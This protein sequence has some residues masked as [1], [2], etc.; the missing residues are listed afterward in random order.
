MSLTADAQTGLGSLNLQDGNNYINSAA[1]KYIVKPKNLKGINGFVFDYEGETNLTLQADITDHF[2]ETN[3][4]V[5]DHIAIRPI[6]ITLKGYVGELVQKA[7]QGLVGALASIQNRLTTVPA[8]LGRYTPSALSTIQK[9]ITQAQ[10]TVNTIN[11]GLARVQN[12]IG[13]FPGATPQK[14]KQQKAFAQL[15]SLYLTRQVFT[16]DTPYGPFDSMVIET[17]TFV[18]PE[19]T[20]YWSDITVTLKQLRFVDTQSVQATSGAFGGRGAQQRQDLT[21]QGKTKG[22]PVKTSLLYSFFSS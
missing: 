15:Q 22:T 21:S 20:K 4:P 1:N 11:Q 13:L 3:D 19:D 7:P 16:L 18:Q 2:L 14:S 6:K 8:Y 17:L 12:I 10:N 5:Q 9:S